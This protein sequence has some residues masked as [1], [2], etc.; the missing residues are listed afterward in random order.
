MWRGRIQ[1]L[2]AGGWTQ[3]FDYLDKGTNGHHQPPAGRRRRRIHALLLACRRGSPWLFVRTSFSLIGFRNKILV[4]MNWAY[5]YLTYG[6]SAR[7]MH[8]PQL[9][10]QRA[11]SFVKTNHPP[12]R[13]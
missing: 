8:G 1:I 4:L 6:R 9:R 11:E 2:L 3:R 5:A 12:N 13:R 7:L 10:A